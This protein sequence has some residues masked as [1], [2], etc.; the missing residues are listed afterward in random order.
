MGAYGFALE[1]A[2]LGV[3]DRITALDGVTR[4]PPNNVVFTVGGILSGWRVLVGPE[5]GSGGLDE[6]QLT[7]TAALTGAA[8][9]VVEV[10]EAIPANTPASG[11][12]RIQRADGRYTR[13]EYSAVN[14]STREFTITS[15]DFSSNNASLGANIY[16]SYI[17][18]ASSGTTISF[19]TIQSG[20]P[21]TLFVS[22][23]FGGTGPDFA[24]SIKPAVTTGS[25]GVTGGSATISAVSDA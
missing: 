1:S 15:H 13:H 20:G 21:Q 6:G 25:L 22:A 17:D 12:I 5:D 3:N 8:V 11:T 10:D 16:I 23:R 2:D 24:D 18:A 9:T 4:A 19:N 14:T 7:N